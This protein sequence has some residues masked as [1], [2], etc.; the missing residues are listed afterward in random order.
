MG[1]LRPGVVVLV[2]FPFS[3]LSASKLR[4]ALVLAPAGAR[5]GSCVRSRATPTAIPPPSRWKQARSWRAGSTANVSRGPQSSSP[6]MSQSLYAVLEFSA[7]RLI[8]AS[9]MPSSGFF[10]PELSEVPSNKGVKLTAAR[11][12]AGRAAAA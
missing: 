8:E 2:R 10:R 9:S 3:D 11:W 5:T 1:G 4:P 7:H 6:P 12:R